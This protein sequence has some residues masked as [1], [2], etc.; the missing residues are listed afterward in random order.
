M[1]FKM[2]ALRRACMF[3]CAFACVT[4]SFRLKLMLEVRKMY[5]KSVFKLKTP[6]EKSSRNNKMVLEEDPTVAKTV[7]RV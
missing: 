7:K 6:G 2:F 3:R 5:K 4:C 1:L